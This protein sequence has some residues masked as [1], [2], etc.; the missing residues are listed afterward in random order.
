MK[1]FQYIGVQLFVLVLLLLN[2]MSKFE[3]RGSYKYF[4]RCFSFCISTD[5]FSV[6]FT[7]NICICSN[8]KR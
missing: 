4:F 8:S 1:I 2:G 6:Y 7:Y 5:G 3:A